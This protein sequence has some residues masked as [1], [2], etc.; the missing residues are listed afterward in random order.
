[1]AFLDSTVALSVA[2]V[3][4]PISPST[5]EDNSKGLQKTFL[6][7][8]AI[9]SDYV[10]FL[11]GSIRPC[12]GLFDTDGLSSSIAALLVPMKALSDTTGSTAEK[13][14]GYIIDLLHVKI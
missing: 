3:L 10:T 8:R 12:D 1:V 9:D 11:F 6:A 14:A 13:M 4:L 7:S 5:S 2:L